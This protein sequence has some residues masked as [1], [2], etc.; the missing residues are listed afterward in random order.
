M[1]WLLT[2]FVIG[3]DQAA[4]P[5]TPVGVFGAPY[6]CEIAGA[7]ITMQ[8]MA[9]TGGQMGQWSYTCVPVQGST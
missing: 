5:P 2:I 6:F 9:E 3:G 4:T 1:M 8:A 7:A